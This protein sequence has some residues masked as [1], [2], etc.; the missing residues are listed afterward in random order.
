MI[1]LQMNHVFV[2]T[3]GTLKKQTNVEVGT[4]TYVVYINVFCL[5]VHNRKAHSS[6]HYFYETLTDMY[7]F[8][9]GI[10]TRHISIEVSNFGHI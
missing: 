2:F 7:A 8:K 5:N 4:T 6:E 1:Q 10:L 3:W 9:I